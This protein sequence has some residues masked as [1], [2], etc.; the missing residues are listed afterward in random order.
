METKNT[1]K[2]SETRMEWVA[3]LMKLIELIANLVKS[4]KKANQNSNQPTESTNQ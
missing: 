3:L 2:K 4:K 1:K